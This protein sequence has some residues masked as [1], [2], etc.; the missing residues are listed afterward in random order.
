MLSAG[1]VE[2]GRPPF[3]LTSH[4]FGAKAASFILPPPSSL[5]LLVL[6]NKRGKQ[7]T[8]SYIAAAVSGIVSQQAPG[9]YNCLCC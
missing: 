2:C 5:K 9:A 6:P 7:T 1:A 8:A 4:G 3:P